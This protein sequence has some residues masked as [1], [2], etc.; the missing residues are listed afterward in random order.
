MAAHAPPRARL[1]ADEALRLYRESAL[2][3]LAA[4]ADEVCRRLHG[5]RVRTFAVDRNINFTNIC[6]CRCRFCA[7][8]RPAD[9]PEAY[10]LDFEAVAEKVREAVALGATHILA[11]GGVHPGLGIG[12]YEDLFRA[13]RE[14]F[15]VVIHALSPPE[16]RALAR[17][18]GMAARAVLERLRGAGLGSLPG[19][20]AEILSDRVRRFIS[21]RK[22]TAGEWIAV[23]REAHALG[24]PTSAT[25]VFG[26]VETDSE[27]IEHLLRL[28]DLQDETGGFQSFIAWPFQVANT[29]LARSGDLGP[30]WRPATAAEYL[31]LVATA[32]LVLDNV[33]NVQASWVTMG[34]RIGQVALR[35]GAN[36]LG[37]TMMEENVVSAA[38]LRP[39]GRTADAVPTSLGRE[40]L[41]RLIREAGFEP[42]QRDCHYRPVGR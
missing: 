4:R 10:V 14:R 19:G 20:G 27:R 34:P 16:V 2:A 26:H 7:F 11:Q 31:R 37:S 6:E 41:E 15:A 25:M 35:F 33:P 9:S 36:D 23:M 24:L 29:D 18:E 21:P 40:D 5:E 32:R 17:R 28:R 22:C 30:D 39:A 8:W 42:E 13:V 38:R 1:S 3:D 12:F